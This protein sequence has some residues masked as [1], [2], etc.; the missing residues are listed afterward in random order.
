M[1]SGDFNICAVFLRSYLS[2][3][4]ARPFTREV[5]LPVSRT[6]VSNVEKE[7]NMRKIKVS[8]VAN[9]SLH[10]PTVQLLMPHLPRTMQQMMEWSA[11]R[12]PGKRSSIS[13]LQQIR[14]T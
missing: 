5:W 14:E 10:L 8:I 9:N 11:T 12:E 3:E 13:F 4:L 7:Q 1:S 6:V 2:W